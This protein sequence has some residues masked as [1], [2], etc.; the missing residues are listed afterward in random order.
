M[1][2]KEQKTEHKFKEWY[3]YFEKYYD[4]LIDSGVDPEVANFLA[5]ERADSESKEL[6]VRVVH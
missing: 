4:E 2:Q 3:S 5:S 1:S 6:E